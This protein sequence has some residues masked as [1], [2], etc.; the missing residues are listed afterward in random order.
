M[1]CPR[2]RMEICRATGSRTTGSPCRR[3]IIWYV[4]D[5]LQMRLQVPFFRR[6]RFKSVAEAASENQPALFTSHTV[7]VSDT[8]CISGSILGLCSCWL[9]RPLLSTL[10][11]QTCKNLTLPAL[12]F[13]FNIY[14]LEKSKKIQRRKNR[15]IKVIHDPLT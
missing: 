10:V 13:S 9:Y 8:L 7:L 11:I 5:P 3:R 12:F 14:S 6:C 15:E 1:L 2:Q 4:G